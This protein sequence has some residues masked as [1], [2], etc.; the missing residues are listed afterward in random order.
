M[1]KKLVAALL[2][3]TIAITGCGGNKPADKK[4]ENKPAAA[5][6]ELVISAGNY[7]M[8]GKYDPT[9]GWGMWGPDIF[10]CKLLKIGTGNKLVNDLAVKGE[11]S[12]D[13][14]KYTYEIRKDAKFADGKPL[15]AKDVVFTFEKTKSRAS[16]MDLTVLDSVKALDD[17]KVEFVLKK[18]WSSFPY[19]LACVGIIPQHAYTDTYGEKPIASG[20]W[21]VLELQKS[22]QLIL[23]PNEHYYGKKSGF[24]KVTIMKLDEDAALAAAKSGKLD[25]V[26]VNA[27]DAATKVN[28]MKVQ[29]FDALDLFL[30]N[31]PTVK[32]SKDA[33]G[34]TVG[35]N[36]T[37]D[38]AIRKALNVGIS[39]KTIIDKAINGMGKP[40]ASA[41]DILHGKTG[42]VADGKVEEAKKI[43]AD[44]GWKDSNGDGVVD[45]NGVN[46]EFTV[47]GRSNDLARYNTVVALA[48]EAKKFGI[49]IVTKSAPWA[50]AR[51][52]LHTPTCWAFVP[53]DPIFIY[54]NFHS[55]QIGKNVIGNPASYS[56][57]AVDELIDKALAATDQTEAA[58]F[59]MQAED[60][61][62]KDVPY[63]M[64]SYP[65][66][67]Y[68]VNE[69]LNIPGYDK[70]IQRGQGMSPIENMNEWTWGK[71]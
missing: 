8:S 59:W 41:G 65:Q 67:V 16:A 60:T 33:K 42:A 66:I 14:L 6:E 49:K 12:P 38:P 55:S 35:N 32:E 45:K 47:T 61:A 54:D 34:Q 43:L 39:R 52:A 64:I 23:A 22:Q 5:K 62:E 4:A 56:N 7:I 51:K 37:S 3:G 11:V 15:T 69:N 25:A 68:L 20:P 46:A 36:I 18:P 48:E 57:K 13:G 30:I 10:H 26:Y 17:Y 44:A 31:L 9:L 19:K 24:K 21:K 70:L 50:E 53:D 58:K 28:G 29:T 27:D 63:L 1:K 2:L 40:T 71:K